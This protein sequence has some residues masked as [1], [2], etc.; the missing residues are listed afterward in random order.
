[1]MCECGG[2]FMEIKSNGLKFRIENKKASVIG[3][4]VLSKHLLI[5]PEIQG[6]PISSIEKYAFSHS[7]LKEV[8]IPS[9]ISELGN[10]AF[11]DCHELKIF[12]VY[13]SNFS[14]NNTLRIRNQVFWN[15][16][17]LEKIKAPN[18]FLTID[19]HGLAHCESLLEIV[20]IIKTL[21]GISLIGCDSL[22]YLIF[23]NGASIED[24]S[25]ADLPNLQ[26][27]TFK[28]NAD[29]ASIVLK[30]MRDK[31]VKITCPST[32]N[33]VNLVYSGFNIVTID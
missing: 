31:G 3:F 4:D 16:C 14:K 2:S 1:M 29:I 5:P 15:C 23:D 27:I 12:S 9:S 10:G 18:M 20:S 25:L 11:S 22:L 28:G 7:E 17:S 13:D 21:K 32:S 24:V 30:L 19:S 26:S 33:L 6:I 8:Q